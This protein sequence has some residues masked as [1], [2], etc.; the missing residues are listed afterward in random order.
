MRAT[1][2]RLRSAGFTI[3]L[4]DFGTGYSSLSYLRK[5]EVD[6][7]KIDRSF[8]QHL[9]DAADSGNII[10]A[11]LALGHAMGLSV[12][13]EGVETAEQQT[14][15]RVAGCKEMQGYY[16]SKPLPAGELAALLEPDG[17]ASSAA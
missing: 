12:A 15:L 1:L 3:A 5:F 13:A 2:S 16:F 6:K 8:I 14:F 9:G 11:V 7:I 4:D 17:R 10:S